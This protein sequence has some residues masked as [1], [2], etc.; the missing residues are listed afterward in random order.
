MGMTSMIPGLVTIVSVL[1][2]REHSLHGYDQQKRS[3]QHERRAAV[4]LLPAYIANRG[5]R[6]ICDSDR[7]LAHPE[8]LPSVF[9]PV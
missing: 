9:T 5:R 1:L 3:L 7:A 4:L 6:G 2:G 8:T